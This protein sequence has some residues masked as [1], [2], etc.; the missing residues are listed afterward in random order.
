MTKKPEKQD[1]PEAVAEARQSVA[2]KVSWLCWIK[3]DWLPWDKP[4]E[5]GFS[6]FQERLCAKCGKAQQRRVGHA[7]RSR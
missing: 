6:L 5:F 1:S 7:T 3:H 2:A 4:R